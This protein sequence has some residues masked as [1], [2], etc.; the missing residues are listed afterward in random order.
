[1]NHGNLA[2]Q[3]MCGACD[4]KRVKADN[5]GVVE[6]EMDPTP[7]PYS[8]ALEVWMCLRLVQYY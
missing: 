2:E 1:M 7:T 6:I 3:K 8:T 5:R 4:G